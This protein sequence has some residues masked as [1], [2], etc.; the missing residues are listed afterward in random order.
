VASPAGVSRPT[1]VIFAGPNGSGKST[2]TR[3]LQSDP[4]AGVPTLYINA[5]DIAASRGTGDQGREERERGA[6]YNA[7]DLRRKY[8]EQGVSFAFETVFSHPSTLLDIA[9]LREAGYSVVLYFVTTADPRVNVGRVAQRVQAGGHPVETEKVVARYHRSLRFAIRA[10]E[11]A[12]TA[13]VFDNTDRLQ[14]IAT[15]TAGVLTAADETDTGAAPIPG[16]LE[17]A[18]VLPLAE[19][20][21]SRADLAAL[22]REGESLGL[23]DEAAGVYAGPVRAVTPHHVLQEVGPGVLVRH[24][25]LLLTGPVEAGAAVRVTYKDGYGTPERI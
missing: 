18:L 15:A 11:D 21:L 22:V 19:R 7:R 8:R 24:D 1:C 25:A 20:A 9:K 12:D 2:L 14:L 10:V 17:R 3:A 6:F 5:D 4:A 13:F 16:Y 23:L